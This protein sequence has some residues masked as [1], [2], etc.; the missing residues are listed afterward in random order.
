VTIRVVPAP[1]FAPEVH[2]NLAME[3][4]KYDGQ[5]E[6]AC[7]CMWDRQRQMITSGRV[8]TRGGKTRTICLSSDF[9]PGE[10]MLHNHPTGSLWPS[11]QDLAAAE[12]L[13][14][15]G[16]GLAICDNFAERLYVV[17]EPALPK[18]KPPAPPSWTL[19]LGRWQLK[20]TKS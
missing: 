4:L 12:F 13:A 20:L 3:F 16:T 8:L 18:P 2:L 6:V 19:S 14:M 7:A 10:L 15:R 9:E 17:R 5:L 1:S 11:E